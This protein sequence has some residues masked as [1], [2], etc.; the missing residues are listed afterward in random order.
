M[1]TISATAAEPLTGVYSVVRPRSP[2]SL[3]ESESPETSLETE[4]TRVTNERSDRDK[5]PVKDR[6]GSCYRESK[7]IL[8]SGRATYHDDPTALSCQH[9]WS[10]LAAKVSTSINYKFQV[11]DSASRSIS[12]PAPVDLL[13]FRVAASKSHRAVAA[14]YGAL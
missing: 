1:K 11:S 4:S 6:F 7:G 8:V 13:N 14:H 2:L 5:K 9:T 10:M 12:F 3:S